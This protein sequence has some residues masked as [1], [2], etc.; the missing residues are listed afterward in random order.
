MKPNTFKEKRTG[1]FCKRSFV[2]ALAA[3]TLFIFASCEEGKTRYEIRYYFDNTEM[4]S[5][6]LEAYELT[7]EGAN[8]KWRSNFHHLDTVITDGDTVEWAS[9]EI[10]DVARENCVALKIY[11]SGWRPNG[12]G[13]YVLDTVFELKIGE[14]NYFYINPGMNWS[15]RYKE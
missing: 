5:D 1:I 14:K 8:G 11:T 15:P 12:G 13:N 2:A 4:Q 10:S 3:L 9:G 7:P 6:F